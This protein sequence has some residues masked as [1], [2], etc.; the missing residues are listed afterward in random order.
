[1]DVT[2]ILIPGLILGGLGVLF[3]ILLGVAD[4]KFRVE[5]DET[6]EQVRALLPGANCGG[7]GR[8][9]CDALAKALCEGKARPNDCVVNTAEKALAIGKLLGVEVSAPT[10]MQAVVKCQGKEGV[11]KDRYDYEGIH[12]CDAAAMVMN[13]RKACDVACLGFGNCE[14]VCVFGA[15]RMGDKGLPEIDPEKCTGCGRCAEE[16]PKGVIELMP[17][18]TKAQVLCRNQNAGKDVRAICSK[19]CIS[20]KMCEKACKFDA[21]HVDSGVAVIDYDNC[22][23]CLCCV[24]KCPTGTIVGNYEGHRPYTINE[25]RCIS[26]GK[27]ME[28]CKFDAVAIN[29]EGKYEIDPEKCRSCGVCEME[30]PQGCI[31]KEG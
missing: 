5:K 12:D 17:Y 22:T 27:C 25:V 10:R 16:C 31:W 2:T 1:M 24:E 4:K 23:G 6:E 7:C 28:S 9:S 26:C 18:G 20:C 19:G 11:C 13:G 29:R 15:I 30:C 8:P 3:G 14:K 21:I